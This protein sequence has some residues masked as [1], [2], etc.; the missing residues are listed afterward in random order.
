M[1]KKTEKIELRIS[2]EGKARLTTLSRARGETVSELIRALVDDALA[3]RTR[4]LAS[5]GDAAM[6]RSTLISRN[7]RL[8]TVALAGAGAL[9]LAI[10]WSFAAQTPAAA[11]T[12]ARVVFAEF[13]HNLDG[14]V[15]KAE[16]A[17]RRRLERLA[18]ARED[19]PIDAACAADFARLDALERQAEGFDAGREDPAETPL[20]EDAA[21]EDAEIFAEFDGDK[22]GAIEFREVRRFFIAEREER[23]DEM[24]RDFDGYLSRDEFSASLDDAWLAEL[25]AEPIG[26][27]CRIAVEAALAERSD[28]ASAREAR[29]E[30]AVLDADLDGEISRE[31]FVTR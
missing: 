28:V 30:F 25:A 3:G 13:D 31:E 8:K 12:E 17:E 5:K 18:E 29:T 22:D 11:Q 6:T 24:D 21:A 14:V 23:F 26:N 1:S 7:A 4:P 19:D 9:A 20:V 16:F 27:A 10:G 2:P 15:T